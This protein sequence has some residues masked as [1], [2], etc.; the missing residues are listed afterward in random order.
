[1]ATTSN[2][3]VKG[4]PGAGTN[5]DGGEPAGPCQTRWA[6]G[7]GPH[8][9]KAANRTR[10]AGETSPRPKPSLTAQPTLP[11]P[12]LLGPAFPGRALASHPCF[13]GPGQG[14]SAAK[15]PQAT[16]E[17]RPLRG[18]R[19]HD[20]AKKRAARTA[21]GRTA[22]LEE[23]AAAVVPLAAHCRRITWCHGGATTSPQTRS[24]CTPGCPTEGGNS[25][26]EPPSIDMMGRHPSRRKQS[27]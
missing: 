12:H 9:G 25:A 10:R 23:S 20:T 16:A 24:A 6:D 15:S 17:G 5:S 21:P 14:C 11:Y 1:M 18:P 13:R 4:E 26:A 3:K 2:R 8:K 7:D 27:R 19:K 22:C